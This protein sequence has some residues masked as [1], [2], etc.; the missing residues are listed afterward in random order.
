[1]KKVI[2]SLFI[3]FSLF[4]VFL[5]SQTVSA[6]T[7][8]SS[9][10]DVNLDIN[11]ENPSSNQNVDASITSYVT[12]LNMA[13][14]T[15]KINGKTVQKGTG[16]KSV[17]FT[18]GEVNTTTSIDVIIQ[19]AEGNTIEKTLN[20]KPVAVDLVWQTDSFVPPF[21]KGKAM[22]SHQNKITFVALP[23]MVLGN[24]SEINPKNLVYKWSKNGSVQDSDS[25]YGKNTFTF[26]SPLI[27]RPFDIEVEVTSASTDSVGFA[28]TFLAPD[29]PSVIF[30]Q[31][32]PLYGIEFQK[33]LSGIASFGN[34]EV[35]IVGMPFFF[36]TTNSQGLIYKWTVNGA[37]IDN[38]TT[39]TTRI[40]RQKQ[41]TVGTSN[42]SLSIENPSK[43]LQFASG[44]FNIE[45][46]VQ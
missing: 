40:F 26:V 23:H 45:L 42:I 1:M 6:Q 12:D 20:I 22:F 31:K 5:T 14:I 27:S 3:V 35:A 29:D 28:K 25:G 19:T 13:G 18:T 38:D 34:S 46:G 33:A 4:S 15:W 10:A 44:N 41:G 37:L 21:Y 9:G 43:I 32:N 17:S 7:I 2:F 36:G 30:Y 16:I 24:G 11:P 39:Q 8:G